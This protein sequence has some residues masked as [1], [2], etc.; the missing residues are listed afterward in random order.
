MME[1]K[2]LHCSHKELYNRQKDMTNGS[3]IVCPDVSRMYVKMNDKILPMTRSPSN[4]TTLVVGFLFK[5]FSI[6]FF[7]INPCTYFNFIF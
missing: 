2:F 5:N 1:V 3:I 4:A 7:P 6:Q